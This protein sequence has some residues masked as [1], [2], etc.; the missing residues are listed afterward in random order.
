MEDKQTKWVKNQKYSCHKKEMF[1]SSNLPFLVFEYNKSLCCMFQASQYICKA[2]KIKTIFKGEIN[3][4]GKYR[5]QIKI[6][7]E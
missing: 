1:S 7:Y 6:K 2:S 3:F 4:K 5:K